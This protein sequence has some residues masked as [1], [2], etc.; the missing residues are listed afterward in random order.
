MPP[1]FGSRRDS[2][3]V[4]FLLDHEGHPPNQ[5]RVENDRPLHARTGPGLLRSQYAG[6]SG[7]GRRLG[8]CREGDET[9]HELRIPKQATGRAA[10]LGNRVRNRGVPAGEPDEAEH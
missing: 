4:R 1:K 2:G 8:Y 9:P 6:P 5:Q 3:R 10:D 7:A